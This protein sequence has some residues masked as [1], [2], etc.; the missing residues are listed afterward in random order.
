MARWDKI[1]DYYGILEKQSAG[2]MKV[3]NMGPTMNENPFLMVIITSAKNMANLETIKKNNLTLVHPGNTPETVIKKLVA[4]GKVVIVQ[5]MSMHA[6]E[7]G[8]TQMAPELAYDLL[9]RT[10]E[11]AQRILDNVVFIEVPCFNPDGEL[12]VADWYNKTLGTPY[13]GYNYPS[14]Y[15]KYIGHDDN[16]DAFMTQMRESQYMASILFTGWRPEVY[17]DHHHM[18]SYGARISLP[19]Y[20]EPT[21]P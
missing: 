11:D 21:R 20:A 15:A 16:R 6:T 3:I 9:T 14:L 19:P 5:S 10:D 18:G 2:R 17:V 7:I 4:N 13:E 8:G 1:V 12:M